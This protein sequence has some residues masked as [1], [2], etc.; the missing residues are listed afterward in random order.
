VRAQAPTSSVASI[1]VRDGDSSGAPLFPADDDDE[2]DVV[3][4]VALD[5]DVAGDAA[6]GAVS[7]SGGTDAGFLG[8]F[9]V[10]VLTGL[11]V[12]LKLSAIDAASRGGGS[13]MV[14][15]DTLA[16]VSGVSAGEP[17]VA[18]AAAATAG[19]G[20]AVVALDAGVDAGVGAA[21]LVAAA[22]A[23]FVVVGALDTGDAGRGCC[24]RPDPPSALL[25]LVP[26]AV[27]DVRSD[28][29]LLALAALGGVGDAVGRGG[30]GRCAGGSVRTVTQS[31][32][33]QQHHATHVPLVPS[34]RGVV[35]SLTSSPTAP[36]VSAVSSAPVA[37][38]RHV[39]AHNSRTHAHAPISSSLSSSVSLYS[40]SIASVDMLSSSSSS[41][42]SPLGASSS[43]PTTILCARIHAIISLNDCHVHACTHTHT[44][45][46]ASCY[47]YSPQQPPPQQQQ[48]VVRAA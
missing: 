2:Y 9:A 41:Y 38:T 35:G 46:F 23:A 43:S 32:R 11:L 22:A 15:P 40:K 16:R 33:A 37:Y 34:T 36:S 18:S 47:C 44:P 6:T 28:A 45:V 25:V 17:I 4:V 12:A 21:L 7:V 8:V 48:R 30:G 19:D 31:T 14:L 39:H 26:G 13:G 42:S 5:A 24:A 10:C 3:V 20:G 1:V 29:R 27:V